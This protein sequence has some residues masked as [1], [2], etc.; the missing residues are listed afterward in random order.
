MHMKRAGGSSSL[1]KAA[2]L[3]AVSH[4]SIGRTTCE[5]EERQN[6]KYLLEDYEKLT[7]RLKENLLIIFL[8]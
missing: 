8:D 4:R 7:A 6:L 5:Q 2:L 3:L 1:Q